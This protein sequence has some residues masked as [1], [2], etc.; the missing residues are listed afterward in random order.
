MQHVHESLERKYHFVVIRALGAAAPHTPYFEP[1]IQMLGCL[2]PGSEKAKQSYLLEVFELQPHLEEQRGRGLHV[3][4]QPPPEYLGPIVLGQR[5]HREGAGV[6]G[7]GE[8]HGDG[9]TDVEALREAA[10]G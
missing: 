9:H 6:D 3:S 8:R 4:D 1:G 10:H 5:A 7:G 2:Q